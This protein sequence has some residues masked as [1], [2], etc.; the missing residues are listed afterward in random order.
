[1]KYISCV[2]FGKL[3]NIFDM[4]CCSSKKE[5]EKLNY[6][7]IVPDR[8]RFGHLN[9][10]CVRS[11]TVLEGRRGMGGEGAMQE[12]ALWGRSSGMRQLTLSKDGDS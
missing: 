2:I 4:L 7:E 5:N 8:R 11:N 9:V 10:V 1:M 6:K 12:G 3:R